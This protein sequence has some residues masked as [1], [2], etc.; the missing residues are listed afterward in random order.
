[1]FN[2]EAGEMS[3]IDKF[4][5]K[6]LKSTDWGIN[7]APKNGKDDRARPAIRANPSLINRTHGLKAKKP[8]DR[9]FQEKIGAMRTHAPPPPF[10]R[11]MR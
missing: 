10:G 4:N 1:M 11:S 8:R 9:P 5:M 7:P 6:I 3:E 2:E